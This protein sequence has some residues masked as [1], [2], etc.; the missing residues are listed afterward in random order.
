MAPFLG[1]LKT[2]RDSVVQRL[3]Q[4]LAADR[5]AREDG[6]LYT[7]D[8][9]QALICFA[10]AKNADDYGKLREHC[11]KKLIVEGKDDPYCRGFVG[12]RYKAGEPIDASG[13]TEGLRV[14]RGFWLGAKAF[15]RAE[16]A[17]TARVVLHGYAHHA[18]VDQDVWIIRN[19]FTFKTRSFAPDSYLVDYD[20]DFVRLVAEATADEELKPVATKSSALIGK[21]AAPCGL[22]Y[23]LVKPDLKTLYPLLD[24]YTFS[25]NDVIGIAGSATTALGITTHDPA[26]A[27]RVLTFCIS[28]FGELRRYYYGRTGEAVND[29]AAAAFEYTS[30]A[31]LAAQLDDE[32]AAARVVQRALVEWQWLLG[33]GAS[34]SSFILT[35]LYLCLDALLSMSS[36]RR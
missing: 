22:L 26:L 11:L 9:A 32:V 23:D 24:I 2:L 16:D 19:Y 25:P 28:R 30:L 14:A 4:L 17:E 21:A 27:R 18:I 10:L 36:T 34:P 31:R 29:T 5:L 13:T 1:E 12:W 35:E 3:S 8:A 33:Q 20:P 15:G 6:Y 7:I